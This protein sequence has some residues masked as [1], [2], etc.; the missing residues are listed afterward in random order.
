MWQMEQ[1]MPYPLIRVYIQESP[2]PSW[3]R[4]PYRTEPEL[5]LSEGSHMSYALQWF[6]F[7]AI[8]AVGYPLYVHREERNSRKTK[9]QQ[10]IYS[11]EEWIS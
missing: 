4:L 10:A 1:Q 2:D 3:T 6:T 8:L 9:L 11:S 7:A 5:D